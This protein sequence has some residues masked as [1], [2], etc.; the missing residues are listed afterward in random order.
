MMGE[1]IRLVGL[2]CEQKQVTFSLRPIVDIV[3]DA[4]GEAGSGV[5][6]EGLTF[7]QGDLTL[8]K[9]RNESIMYEIVRSRQ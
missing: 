1:L 7:V 3:A 8:D 6:N 4:Q 2:N 9:C 5:N